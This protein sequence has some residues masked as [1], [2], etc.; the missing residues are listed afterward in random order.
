MKTQS[1]VSEKI[2]Q[3][4]I[5]FLAVLNLFPIYWLIS[6]TFKYSS[7]ITKMPPDW[8]PKRFVID[9]YIDIFT[10][11]NAARW[12]LN[13]L[14]V[15]GVSTALIVLVS[16]MASYA[17]SKL[18]FRGRNFLFAIF[19]G[20]LMIPKESYIVPLFGFMRDLHLTNT[21]SSMILPMVALPFGTFLLKSFFDSI[22]DEIRESGKMDGA[23]EWTIF[24]TLIV[25]M[26]AAGIAALF[27]LEFVKGW[28]DYL[29][30]LVMSKTDE[31]KTLMVGIT[32]LME[33]N[34]PDMARKLT[35]ASI[36]AIPM[37]IV[38]LS[39]QKYFTKG[40][41]AGAVKG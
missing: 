39:F 37:I 8:F 7:E 4:V 36:S 31:M 21:Y 22:P 2:L 35:G 20:T 33:D 34:R 18:K 29:W 15:A 10:S 17:F 1:S 12:L 9:S 28:N 27:I 40:I 32:S 30:Q 23:S 6:N 11:T 5:V 13:S 19:I 24:Y 16:T 3:A 38:F 26:A 25:P 14:I 41:A